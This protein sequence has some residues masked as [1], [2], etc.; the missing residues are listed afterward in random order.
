M[1]QREHE[2]QA[3]APA[4]DGPESSGL[5]QLQAEL[6]EATQERDQF[7]SLAQRTQADLVN[8][9]RRVEEER[10]ELQKTANA[11]LILDLLA[12][13]DDFGRALANVPAQEDRATWWEGVELIH[14][15]LQR[16]LEREGISP[17]EAL[18]KPFDPWEHEALLH[19]ESPDRPEGEVVGVIQEGYKLHGKLLR[20]AQVVVAK[21]PEAGASQPHEE[22]T[23]REET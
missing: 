14:R 15:K 3:Q 17:I 7:R 18:G 11:R 9:R 20:P 5:D 23:D 10:Q 13:M 6:A 22:N 2:E 16:V 4:T 1:E 12:I 21:R 8:Y 19:L